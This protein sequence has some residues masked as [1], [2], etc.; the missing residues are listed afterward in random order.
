[1]QAYQIH[2]TALVG[3][4]SLI[5]L[6]RL[7]ASISRISPPKREARLATPDSPGRAKR[8]PPYPLSRRSR[9]Q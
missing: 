3:C 4:S 6:P 9:R 7:D 1:M 2:G 5:S 8:L